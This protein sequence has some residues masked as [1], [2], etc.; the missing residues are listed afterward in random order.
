MEGISTSTEEGVVTSTDYHITAMKCSTV[1]IAKPSGK[2]FSCTIKGTGRTT[3]N[4]ATPIYF[5]VNKMQVASTADSYV[6]TSKVSNG[7]G[8]TSSVNSN[9]VSTRSNDT[10]M[11][12]SWTGNKSMRNIVAII[13]DN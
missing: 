8:K 13:I 11:S 4:K 2:E 10:N 5:I 9:K 7:T 1:V 3:H 6:S 12:N